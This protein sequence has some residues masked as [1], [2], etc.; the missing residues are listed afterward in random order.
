[1]G[2]WGFGVLAGRT[3]FC[4][5]PASAAASGGM[6]ISKKDTIGGTAL[7]CIFSNILF[8]HHFNKPCAVLYK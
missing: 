5:A 6:D 4:S 3:Q 8:T 2:F 7:F 1:M